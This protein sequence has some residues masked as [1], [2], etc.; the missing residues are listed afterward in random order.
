MTVSKVAYENDSDTLVLPA[1]ADYSTKLGYAMYEYTDGRARICGANADMTGVLM[2]KPDAQDVYCKLKIRG[3]AEVVLG[4]AVSAGNAMATR[5]DGTFGPQSS[6]NPKV[7][8]ALRSGSSGDI[9][10]MLLGGGGVAQTGTVA[11]P[12]GIMEF[13]IPLSTIT[14]ASDLKTGIKVPGAGTIID[15]QVDVEV[16]DDKSGKAATLYLKIGSTAV[17]GAEVPLTSATCTALATI[18]SS[19]AASANNT[20]TDSSTLKICAKTVTSF[21]GSAGWITVRILTSS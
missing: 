14:S 20:F 18:D 10:P 21:A 4:Y 13:R 16:A 11:A 3:I 17:T 9:I 7:G 1:Y 6:T 15:M 8:M 12:P 19:G 2:D 5:S